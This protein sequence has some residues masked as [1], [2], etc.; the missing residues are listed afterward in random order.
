MLN[1]PDLLETTIGDIT[2]TSE[3]S[4]PFP[5]PD[6]IIVATRSHDLEE[7]KAECESKYL[8]CNL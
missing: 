7:P 3:T 5:A 8:L 2:R 4:A 6:D 1:S